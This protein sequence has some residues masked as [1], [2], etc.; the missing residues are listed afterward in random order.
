MGGEAFF[1]K[2]FEEL[3]DD[4]GAAVSRPVL[5][6]STNA[7]MID[8]AWAER[9]VR[10]PFKSV[11]ISIDGGTVETF[12]RLRRGAHLP[13]VLENVRRIQRVKQ[14]LH[15][16]FP[17]LDSFFVLMRSNFREIQTYLD[18]LRRLGIPKVVLQTIMVDER[19]R[20][21]ETTL[22]E[23][24][25]R[26]PEELAELH[27]LLVKSL[28]RMHRRLDPTRSGRAWD[29]ISMPRRRPLGGNESSSVQTRGR[30]SS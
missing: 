2:G 16:A 10:T 29:P 28:P 4:V 1:L 25:L 3:L 6:L 11:T 21:R 27:A 9:I 14:S 13:D 15:S 12:D 8:D 30:R 23:E 22:T 20:S 5:S 18:M 26:D 19:N 7:T 17:R 24:V